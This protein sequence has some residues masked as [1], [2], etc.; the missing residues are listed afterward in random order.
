MIKIL[1]AAGAALILSACASDGY[2]Y[3][4]HGPYG[5]YDAGRYH[6]GYRYDG[7]R[8]RG[9]WRGGYHRDDRPRYHRWR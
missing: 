2:G 4:R 3:G 1:L 7:R 9:H 6:D 5:A 8:A